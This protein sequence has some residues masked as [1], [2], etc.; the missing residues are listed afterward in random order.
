MQDFSHD[1]QLEQ[2]RQANEDR[3]QFDAFIWQ[4]T[5]ASALTVLAGAGAAAIENVADA[6]RGGILVGLATLLFTLWHA[7]LKHRFGTDIRTTALDA[8][9]T[10]WVKSHAITKK[11]QRRT[12]ISEEEDAMTIGKKLTGIEA[13]SSVW[14][15]KG[16][17]LAFTLVLGVLGIVYIVAATGAM[18]TPSFLLPRSPGES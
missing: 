9:E 6:V 3:R 17:M 13:V 8:I 12:K 4:N 11:I 7:L 1:A 18:D 5:V 16:V 2:Y 10:Q 15:L 14:I